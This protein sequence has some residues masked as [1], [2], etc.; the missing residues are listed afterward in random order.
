MKNKLID[1]NDHL[2]AQV[3]RLSEEGLTGDKLKEEI[4]RSK[5]VSSAASNIINNA[6]LALDAQKALSDNLIKTVP[7]MIG[8]D[9]E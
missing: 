7:K 4:V 2:F 8:S 9:S 5:A 6:R 1:L 3:E